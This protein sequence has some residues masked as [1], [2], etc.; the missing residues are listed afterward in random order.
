MLDQ[1]DLRL[2]EAQAKHPESHIFVIRGSFHETFT[3]P[4]LGLKNS[5]KWL[6]LDPYR[7]HA[8]IGAY[9]TGFLNAYLKDDRS[10]LLGGATRVIRKSKVLV[11]RLSIPKN[12][13][14]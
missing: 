4:A 6:L 8:I 1:N 7:A 14:N 2:L 11:P 13:R 12:W 5:V 9:L 10:G 3:Y